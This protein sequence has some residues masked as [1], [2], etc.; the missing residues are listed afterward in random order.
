MNK[1]VYRCYVEKKQGFDI[2]AQSLQKELSEF[3]GLKSA[4]V[5]LFYRYDVQG[6]PQDRVNG[7]FGE[8]I[9]AWDDEVYAEALPN[10]GDWRVLHVEPVP[11]QYDARANACEQAIQVYLEGERPIV[12]TGKVY[13]I[14]GVSEREYE[15]VLSYLVNP[16]EERVACADKPATL[17]DDTSVQPADVAEVTDYEAL[18]LAMSDE[19]VAAV[20]AYFESE[21]R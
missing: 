10:T 11:G 19:D 15:Q 16:V 14:D 9:A 8:I 3:V 4:Q 5:R 13:V 21:G 7:V 1:Q 17:E 18:G 2:A 6:I 12:N 20:K